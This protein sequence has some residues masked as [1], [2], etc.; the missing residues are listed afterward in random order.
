MTYKVKTRYNI[1]QD[2]NLVRNTFI[3][4]HFHEMFSYKAELEQHRRKS[5][6]QE[7]KGETSQRGYISAKS[8]SMAYN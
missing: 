2:H 5:L 1:W 4:K 7:F 8:S 3:N 6:D